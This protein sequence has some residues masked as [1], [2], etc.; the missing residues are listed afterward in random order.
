MIFPPFFFPY[1]VSG[2][3]KDKFVTLKLGG[4]KIII[5]LFRYTFFALLLLLL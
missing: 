5:D 1:I 2:L 4:G 3:F